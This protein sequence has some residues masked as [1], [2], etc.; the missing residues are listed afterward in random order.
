M[1][2]APRDRYEHRRPGWRSVRRSA[3]RRTAAWGASTPCSTV[4]MKFDGSAPRPRCYAPATAAGQG[5]SS[6]PTRCGS[7]RRRRRTRPR[8]RRWQPVVQRRES[9]QAAAFESSSESAPSPWYRL[10]CLRQMSVTGCIGP[11]P[12]RATAIAG[13]QVHRQFRFGPRCTACVSVV[14]AGAYQP[15]TIPPPNGGLRSPPIGL[16]PL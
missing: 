3:P 11:W 5:A 7:R 9:L 16:R 4:R 15:S 2:A 1:A 14:S 8:H 10:R 6:A 12:H 13:A